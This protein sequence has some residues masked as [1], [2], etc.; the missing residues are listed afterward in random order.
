MFVYKSDGIECRT[1]LMQTHVMQNVGAMKYST[2]NVMIDWYANSIL[3]SLV[4]NS[5]HLQGFGKLS[6]VGRWSS[7]Q[8]SCDLL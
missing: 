3:A 1:C 4:V 8:G 2:S 5:T 6:G 7:V